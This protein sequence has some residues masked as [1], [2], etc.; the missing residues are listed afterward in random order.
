MGNTIA[1]LAQDHKWA[2]VAERIEARAVEDVNV[3][4]GHLDWTTLSLASWEGQLDI[5]H[6][7]LRFKHIR[8]D[9]P[10]LD[11]MTPLHEAAKH[12]HLEVARALIDAGA[13]P[14]ATNNEGNKPLALANGSEMSEFLTTCMLPVGVCAER[15]E[16]HEVKRRVTRRL[17]SDV[18]ASFGERGWCLLSYCAIHDQVELV[19]LLVRYKDICVDH[20]NVDG[21]TALHEAAKHNHLQVLSILVRAGADQS[22]LNTSGATPVDLATMDGRALLELAPPV[23][24][25]PAEVHQCPHCTYENPRRDGAC[26]MCKMDMQTSEDAVA[27]LMER[28]ALMEEATLCT[29]CEERPKDTVFTCGHETCMTCAQQMTSCPNCRK[30]ITARIRRFV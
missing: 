8:V 28:I 29:I 23:V 3:T 25:A 22:L 5:V 13:N 15:H 6:L 2:Q 17:L 24:M 9:Q 10:N 18:N 11:G 26:A 20:A 7:L 19:D 4:T 12:G 21:M 1:Q 27:A 30:P 14:H 16:W